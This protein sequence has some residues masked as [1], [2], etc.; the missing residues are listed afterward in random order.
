MEFFEDRS[1]VYATTL[2][3]VYGGKMG[4]KIIFAKTS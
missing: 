2:L 4:G 1:V 3:F